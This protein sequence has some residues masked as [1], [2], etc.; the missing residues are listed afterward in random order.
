MYIKLYKKGWDGF[1]H[2]TAFVLGIKP[3]SR[4]VGAP[5]RW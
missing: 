2:L 3:E 4:T 5:S 1:M